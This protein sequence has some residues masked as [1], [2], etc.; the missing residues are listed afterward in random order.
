MKR[1]A[2]IAVVI[3]ALAAASAYAECKMCSNMKDSNMMN[4]MGARLCNGA[5]NA[6]LGWSEIF[7]RPGLVAAEGGNIIVG[8]FRGLGNALTRTAVGVVEVATFWTPG[9]AVAG[10]SDCP[11]CSYK[12]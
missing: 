8:F 3:V 5:C 1:V 2:L 12:K 6:L 9:D 4:V 7:F 10:M 11:V